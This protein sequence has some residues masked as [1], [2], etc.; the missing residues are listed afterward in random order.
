MIT[1]IIFCVFAGIFLFLLKFRSSYS[2][3]KT[4]SKTASQKRAEFMVA[5]LILSALPWLLLLMQTIACGY[6][7]K[8]PRLLM[9]LGADQGCVLMVVSFVAL[10]FSYLAVYSTGHSVGYRDGEFQTKSSFPSFVRENSS[11]QPVEI[12]G[13]IRSD[14]TTSVGNELFYD[15]RSFLITSVVEKDSH[16]KFVVA[17]NEPNPEVFPTRL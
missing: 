3:Q 1:I 5:G 8:C 7:T 12:R 11:G 14:S 10:V 9:V 16:F 6:N 4:L 17:V 15:K 13:Y 2:L